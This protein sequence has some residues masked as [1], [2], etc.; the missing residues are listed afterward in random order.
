[1]KRPEFD[2]SRLE[3]IGALAPPIAIERLVALKQALPACGD[4]LVL[5]ALAQALPARV[6]ELVPEV[7]LALSEVA[8]ELAPYGPRLPGD[9]LELSPRLR[10][11]WLRA[12][13]AAGD[14]ARGTEIEIDEPQLLQVVTG[15]SPAGVASPLPLLGR[16]VR[17]GDVRLRKVAL[18]WLA[19]LVQELAVSGQDALSCVLPLAGDGD[20]HVRAEAIRLLSRPWLLGLSPGAARRREAAIRAALRD[21]EPA[22]AAA[23]ALATR[24]LGQRAW[25][26]EIVEDA[27][28]PPATRAA[29]MAALGGLAEPGDL[30][31]VLAVA[32][33]DPLRFGR[34]RARAC[35]RRT[36]MACSFASRTCRP[37]SRSTTITSPGPAKS[38][39]AS[40]T[41]PARGS[42]SSSRSSP[43]ATRA[44]RAAPRSWRTASGPGRSA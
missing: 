24:E 32:R 5:A 29:A 3:G 15:W 42:S 2:V 43:P 20:T 10:T 9:V 25:L 17:A 4:P 36:G 18:G 28:A 41:S 40:R 30:D 8:R 27:G 22:V 33:Q 14:D 31:M 39:S 44:G 38:W 1:M 19:P 6:G 12:T 26:A 34:A 16:L 11:A 13:L 23:A 7:C 21:P 37:C 35:W